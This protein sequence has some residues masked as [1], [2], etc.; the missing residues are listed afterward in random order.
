MLMKGILVALM[1]L[2]GF[3]SAAK[4]ETARFVCTNDTGAPD[5]VEVDFSGKT[6][7]DFNQENPGG[8][9]TPD[10]TSA[11]AT[12]DKASIKWPD[13]FD[14]TTY[15]IDRTTNVLKKWF[16]GYAIYTKQCVQ[17]PAGSDWQ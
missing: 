2:C 14:G 8:A 5:R 13:T 9:I 4:A 11:P 3:V 6:V 15:S 10:K 12:I 1:V 17:L 16:E 7:L